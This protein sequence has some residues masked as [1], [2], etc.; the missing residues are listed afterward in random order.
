VSGSADGAWDDAAIAEAA[1]H[2][3]AAL[4]AALAQT[5]GD[6]SVLRHDLRPDLSIPLDPMAGWTE[7]VLADAQAL[8]ERTLKQWRDS[9]FPEPPAASLE[10]LRRIM[11]FSVGGA[12]DDEYVPLLYEELGGEGDDPR[13]PAWRAD[14]VAPGRRFRVAVVGAGMSGLVAAHRL[15]QA[16][17]DLVVL[18]KND[19]VGGTWFENSYPGCRVDVPNHF[20]SYSFAQKEDW[21][22][23][24]SPRDVLLDYFRHCA[25]S[26]GLRDRVRFGTEVTAATWSDDHCTWTL[27]LRSPK[28]ATEIEVEAV[29]FALGQLNRPHL[30]EIEGIDSFAGPAFHSARWRHEVDLAD[31]RVAV[32]G[33][34]ASGAQLVPVIAEQAAELTVFQRTPNWLLPAPDYQ[35][36]IPDGKL[37]LFRHVPFYN[38]WYRFWIFY[39]SAD[40]LLPATEVDAEWPEPG[41]VGPGNAFAR[42]YM[43][44]YLEEQFADRTD[45]LPSVIPPY[46]PFAKRMVFDNG[47]WARALKRP[48]VRL[49]TD[50]ITRITPDAV[51]TESARFGADVLVFA[52]GFL[53]SHFLE[54]VRVTGRDGTDL[55][56]M[57]KGDARAYLGV[58]VPKFPNLFMLYG[59]NTNIVVN[60]S[61]IY[62]S[63]CE[64]RYVVG[65]LRLLLQ[66][67][68]D[69]LEVREDVHDEYNQAVDEANDRRVWGAARVHTWYKNALGRVS[70]N[71][72]FTLQDYW[73][74]TREPDPDDY[75]FMSAKVHA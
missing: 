6:F 49:V 74:R 19:E 10:D 33:T 67:G 28:G 51:E 21:P 14:D 52:T 38:Q 63:E 13:A 8:A 44:G 34:G 55:Y 27:K 61:I 69:A 32:I 54:P 35:E 71:W 9:G 29:V 22:F 62:F 73:R 46:P 45:L 56:A 24:F 57:W 26:F 18:E 36:R 40:A 39:R 64:V 75:T 2:T 37:W 4:L 20:Y 15:A 41:S 48:N 31:K 47:S 7:S 66:G 58:T 60:G 3:D 42:A 43:Q 12:V 30:P 16:G 70:Q 68:H 59:P 53:A 25:E 65:C 17:V 50:P 5:T 1:R 23:F 11:E 72:P